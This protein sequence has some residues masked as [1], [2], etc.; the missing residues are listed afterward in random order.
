M[1][2]SYS[3][4]K[5]TMKV[6]SFPS[7]KNLSIP[8]LSY[9]GRNNMGRISFKAKG[10]RVPRN[11]RLVDFK[12]FIWDLPALVLRIEYDPNRTSFVALIC[13]ANGILSYVNATEGLREGQKLRVTSDSKKFLKLGNTLP[14]R[15]FAEGSIVN[16][17][18]FLAFHGGVFARSGGTSVVLL[19]KL[20]FNQIL[21][22]LPSKEEVI[23]DG[24][25]LATCGRVSNVDRKFFSYYKAGQLANLGVKPKVRGVAKNPVDHPHGGGGGRCLVTPWAKVAKNRTT[26]NISKPAEHIVRS[27]KLFVR[28]IFVKK[29]KK[30]SKRG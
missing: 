22:K 8:L 29:L 9:A 7:V 1:T 13:Y 25:C 4:A 10:T 18:E 30:K 16:T 27:R 20:F 14:M 5:L 6:Q 23:L 26:R 19:K 12:R 17:V 28:K 24:D 15:L 3:R 2:Y 21:A 11:Y